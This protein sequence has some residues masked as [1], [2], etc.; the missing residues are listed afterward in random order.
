MCGYWNLHASQSR[1]DSEVLHGAISSPMYYLE[2][3]PAAKSG[4]DTHSCDKPMLAGIS[5][6][7]LQIL[8]G[9]G[10]ALASA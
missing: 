1:I 4:K 2:Q 6:P 3:I 10:E 7:Q 8:G 5:Q 9:Y